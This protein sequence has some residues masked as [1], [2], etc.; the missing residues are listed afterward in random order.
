MCTIPAS[1]EFSTDLSYSL[2]TYV[3]L[4]G[5]SIFIST[6]SLKFFDIP[7]IFYWILW[8][9]YHQLGHTN[10]TFYSSQKYNK[11]PV[12]KLGQFFTEFGA[13]KNTQKRQRIRGTQKHNTALFLWTEQH[14]LSENEFV[15]IPPRGLST[16]RS[17]LCAAATVT[18]AHITEIHQLSH[19]SSL[20][21]SHQRARQ[22]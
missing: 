3:S 7:I 6:N 22:I 5:E 4:F 14:I 18:P 2:F 17:T 10:K 12:T 9:S 11:F 20:H 15:N 13:D 19:G 16:A 8:S 1:E 21:L